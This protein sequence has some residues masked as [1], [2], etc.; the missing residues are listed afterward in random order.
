[1]RIIAAAVIVGFLAGP[2]FAQQ[3]SIPKYGEEDKE[4]SAEE[5]NAEREADR[6]YRR[7]LGNI[8][9]QKPVDPWGNVRSDSSQKPEAKAPAKKTKTGTT[10]N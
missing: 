7:S 4:K 3:K 9:E 2:A 5:K 10:S 6:A 1:M 8:P